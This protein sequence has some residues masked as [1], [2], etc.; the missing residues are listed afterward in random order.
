MSL[1]QSTTIVGTLTISRGTAITNPPA[2]G[3]D[4]SVIYNGG[5]IHQRGYEW[6]ASE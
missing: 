5:D 3:S 1:G 6:S 2:Y 4:S